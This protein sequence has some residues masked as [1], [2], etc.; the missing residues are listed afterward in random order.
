VGIICYERKDEHEKEF[1]RITFEM[2]G[3]KEEALKV[4]M[5]K[6]EEEE[7]KE[8][9][10]ERKKERTMLSYHYLSRTI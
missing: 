4:E 2:T 10:K 8:R 1:R 5:S 9:K 3:I 7:E 6:E